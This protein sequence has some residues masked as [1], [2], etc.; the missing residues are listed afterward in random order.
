M[1]FQTGIGWEERHT[2]DLHGVPSMMGG[3]DRSLTHP[4]GPVG[5]RSLTGGRERASRV[6]WSWPNPQKHW[7]WQK[8]FG[9]FNRRIFIVFLLSGYLEVFLDAVWSVTIKVDLFFF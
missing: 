8:L 1:N 4:P 9:F 5:R 7:G 6:G 3:G 2:R